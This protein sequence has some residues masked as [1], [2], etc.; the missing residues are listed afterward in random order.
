MTAIYLI[1][2]LI[3]SILLAVTRRR[4]I[5]RVVIGAFVV[6]QWLLTVHAYRHRGQTELTYFTFDSLSLILLGI[7]GVVATAAFYHSDVFFSTRK[8]W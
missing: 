6:V 7:L 5:G 2:V 3:F 8:H 1:L 4:I